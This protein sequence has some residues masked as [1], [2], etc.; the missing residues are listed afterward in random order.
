LDTTPAD[1]ELRRL[2]RFIANELEALQGLQPALLTA[3]EV[4]K[5][6]GLSPGWVYKYAR[7]LGGQRMGSGPKAR[8]RF[9]ARDVEICLSGFNLARM[10]NLGRDRAWRG[11]PRSC[12]RSGRDVAADCAPQVQEGS[13]AKH[14]R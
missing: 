2:A 9:R 6:Y 8:L 5:Q 11:S 12:Y 10:R 4:A 1:A 3:A 7:E 14:P 13:P